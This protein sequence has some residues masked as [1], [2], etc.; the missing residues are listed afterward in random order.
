MYE[1]LIQFLLGRKDELSEQD[2]E[3]FMDLLGRALEV[4]DYCQ[5]LEKESVIE[6]MVETVAL[7]DRKERE[8]IS[9]AIGSILHFEEEDGSE[10]DGDILDEKDDQVLP[11]RAR[12]V[13]R[14][15]FGGATEDPAEN[16]GAG[17]DAAPR[18]SPEA[19]KKRRT[20]DALP[21]NSIDRT[22]SGQA[23]ASISDKAEEGPGQALSPGGSMAGKT[24]S[25]IF[26]AGL[27]P[28]EDSGDQF[29]FELGELEE[30]HTDGP[31]FSFRIDDK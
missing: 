24:M 3:E 21:E 14:G 28:S 16:V 22:M 27:L 31:E 15:R 13:R 12:K 19:A 18:P 9:S 4:H 6:S 29:R 7:K 23:A 2:V 11:L 25:Q 20:A 17:T 26:S 1:D 8:A 30:A 10:H 5:G